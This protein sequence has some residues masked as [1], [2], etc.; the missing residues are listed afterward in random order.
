MVIA[1]GS[2]QAAYEEVGPSSQP[3][4]DVEGN[5]YEEPEAL[6]TVPQQITTTVTTTHCKFYGST[7]T[8]NTNILG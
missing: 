8:S 7:C 6:L 4:A 1:N 5:T 3:D 2:V